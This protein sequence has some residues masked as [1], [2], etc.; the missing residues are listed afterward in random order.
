MQIMT[1]RSGFAKWLNGGWRSWSY[2]LSCLA[3]QWRKCSHRRHQSAQTASCVQP[4]APS[5]NIP[6]LVLL[7]RRE[8]GSPASLLCSVCSWRELGGLVYNQHRLPDVELPYTWAEEPAGS[9]LGGHQRR[10]LS[11]SM[12]MLL[13]VNVPPPSSLQ[14]YFPF[15]VG[16]EYQLLTIW[17]TAS[18]RTSHLVRPTA[19]SKP[20]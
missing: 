16:E 18:V 14:G 5:A 19:A 1:W 13:G 7:C 12:D 9:M 3:L 8:G 6:E 20:V 15:Q 11:M 17:A 2:I 4:W 10:P